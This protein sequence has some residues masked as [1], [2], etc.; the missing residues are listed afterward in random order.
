MLIVLLFGAVFGSLWLLLMITIIRINIRRWRR[1]QRNFTTGMQTDMTAFSG[2]DALFPDN[3]CPPG[4][5][6]GGPAGGDS[7]S[8]FG[9]GGGGL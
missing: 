9:A 8:G 5:D 1:G 6:G 7:G 2:S 3:P 4:G